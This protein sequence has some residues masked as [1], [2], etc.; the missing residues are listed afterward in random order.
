MF[1]W[2][3]FPLL[4]QYPLSVGLPALPPMF[5][6]RTHVSKAKCDQK[7]SRAHKQ[8]WPSPCTAALFAHLLIT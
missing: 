8:G 2:I 6:N 3:R 4:P 5:C 1:C 7:R